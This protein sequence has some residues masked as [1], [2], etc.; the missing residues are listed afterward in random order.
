MQR[1][2]L[3]RLFSLFIHFVSQQRGF[4]SGCLVLLG[5]GGRVDSLF[6]CPSMIGEWR[7]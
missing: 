4:G 1:G 2:G 7:R 3:N 5:G 6:F